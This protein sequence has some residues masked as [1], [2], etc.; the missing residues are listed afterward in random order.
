MKDYIEPR[1]DFIAL[2]NQNL[3]AGSVGVDPGEPVNPTKSRE[4]ETLE[5]FETF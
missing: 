2:E 5:S 4:W 3:L 1:M